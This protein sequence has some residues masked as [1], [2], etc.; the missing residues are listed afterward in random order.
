MFYKFLWGKVER[1]RRLKVIKKD[2]EGGLGMVHLDSL[3]SSIKAAVSCIM[4]ADPENDNWI[5]ITISLFST[6]GGLDVL[7][8]F[9]FESCLE[10][11][12]L[13]HMPLFYKD[14]TMSY[15]K[16]FTL[17]FHIHLKVLFSINHCGE[18]GS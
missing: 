12:E 4:K 11:P 5:Q 9:T 17:D 13:N 16:A 2:S 8:E 6:L 7:R 3:F 10:L 14:V 1:L 18:T 15:S